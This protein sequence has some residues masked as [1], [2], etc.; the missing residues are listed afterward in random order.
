MASPIHG[1][2]HLC[3]RQA[4][5][6]QDPIT[7]MSAVAVVTSQ[8]ALGA[9]CPPHSY[10]PTILPDESRPCINCQAAGPHGKLSQQPMTTKSKT[11]GLPG[12]EPKADNHQRARR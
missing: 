4:C 3:G 10:R 9:P 5:I 11:W 8:L 12:L 6:Y 2:G 7:V 1:Y